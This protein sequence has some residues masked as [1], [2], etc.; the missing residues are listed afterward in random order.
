MLN[1]LRKKEA[2]T[3]PNY[4]SLLNE[5]IKG[6]KEGIEPLK[7]KT[8][9]LKR[10]IETEQAKI[11]KINFSRIHERLNYVLSYFQ[12][13]E[14][15]IQK[16]EGFVAEVQEQAGFKKKK[17]ENI[18]IL[19]EMCLNFDMYLKELPEIKE[20]LKD[21]EL[22]IKLLT[23]PEEKKSKATILEF[24]E[25]GEMIKKA[26]NKDD[27]SN[28]SSKTN[29]LLKILPFL[30]EEE[31]KQMVNSILEDNEYFKDIKLAVIFP[32]LE[33]EDCDKLFRNE[34][35][36]GSKQIQ[37]LIPFVSETLLSEV[38]DDYLNGKVQ[39]D[40]DIFYPFLKMEDIK[41]IF[42]NELKKEE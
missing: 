34:L 6:L 12:D 8:I 39:I 37:S 20:E 26:F 25:F 23:K 3:S 24:K 30:E 7:G 32:F 13:Y 10:T 2:E 42:F 4:V 11:P 14:Q 15:N 36:K 35:K 5:R 28:S 21:I 18:E 31:L 17:N 33:E 9:A 1:R 38:V 40:M 22:N 27:S 19:E 16:A 29:K 41:K